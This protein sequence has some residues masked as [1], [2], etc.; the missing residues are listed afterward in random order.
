MSAWIEHAD[1][2]IVQTCWAAMALMYARYP[3]PEP[4]SNAVKLVMSRQRPVRR[5]QLLAQELNLTG[6]WNDRTDRGLR[7]RSR[8]CSTRTAPFLT[9]TS[10]SR[11]Q[12]GCLGRPKGIWRSSRRKRVS[13]A[14]AKEAMV[15]TKPIA[16][17]LILSHFRIS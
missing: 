13:T 7:R 3:D 2:Q 8:V 15:F 12:F 14:T 17:V 9:R 5:L 11:F 6:F 16:V 1:T 4:V 10:N